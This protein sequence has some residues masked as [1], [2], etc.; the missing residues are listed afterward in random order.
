MTPQRYATCI[1]ACVKCALACHHCSV[2]CLKEEDVKPMVR[3]IALDIDCAAFCELSAAAMARESENAK[4]FC[5][6]C[7]EICQACGDECAQHKA[8][9]CQACAKA[10]HTC[11]SVCREM[12]A[13]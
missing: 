12:A 1:D 5:R 4:A 6:V 9:H 3:C 10:C 13:A 8:D 2:A 7:A 11:A